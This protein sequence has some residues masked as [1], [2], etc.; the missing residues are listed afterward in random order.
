VTSARIF[1][2]YLAWAPSFT[3]EQF[4]RLYR[5]IIPLVYDNQFKTKGHKS[6]GSRSLRHKP[7]AARFLGL[8]VRNPL[9]AWMSVCCDC[10]WLLGRGLCDIHIPFILVKYERNLGFWRYLRHHITFFSLSATVH[11]RP[12]LAIKSSFIPDRL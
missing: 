9:E 11:C 6:Q 1:A 8:R 7:A 2:S 5:E 12:C 4:V 3:L 10:C